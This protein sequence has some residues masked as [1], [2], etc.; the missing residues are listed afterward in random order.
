MIRIPAPGRIENRIV[1]RAANPYLAFTALIAA[2]LDGIE[3][4]LDCP[5][6]DQVLQDALGADYA[7][8]R[9][10]AK[11]EEWR[12]SRLTVSAWETEHYLEQY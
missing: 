4:P 12:Q 11:R 3:R 8:T 1:D 5:E 6:G 9:L 7:A 2:G 10:R